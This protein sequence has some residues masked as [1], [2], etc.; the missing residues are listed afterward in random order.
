MRLLAGLMLLALACS[1]SRGDDAATERQRRVRV[2]LALSCPDGRCERKGPTRPVATLDWFVAADAK[3]EVAPPPRPAVAADKAKP[4]AP[5]APKI[6]YAEACKRALAGELFILAVKESPRSPH[7][8]YGSTVYEC[9]DPPTGAEPGHYQLRAHDGELRWWKS[10][11]E[12]FVPAPRPA[13]PKKKGCAC[14]PDC[15]KGGCDVCDCA[16]PATAP[17]RQLWQMWDAQ[18][19]TWY[20]W[21]DPAPTPMPAAGPRP[22]DWQVM[23]PPYQTLTPGVVSPFPVCTGT[24]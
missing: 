15:P 2:A 13:A 10:G 18:G 14:G 5:A 17:A 1:A 7:E 4:A 16:T 23:R 11:F 21:R 19:R 12:K 8:F 20:E 3:V 9:T 24:A 6:T 22:L